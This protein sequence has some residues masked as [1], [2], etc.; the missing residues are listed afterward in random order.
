MITKENWYISDENLPVIQ[1]EKKSNFKEFIDSE[2]FF[3]VSFFL[4]LAL[5]CFGAYFIID[6]LYLQK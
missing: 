5:A 3:A 2:F 6:I 1:F 4:I